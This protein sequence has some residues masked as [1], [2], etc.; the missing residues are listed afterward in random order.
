MPIIRLARSRVNAATIA[1][2]LAAATTLAHAR[3]TEEPAV[4]AAKAAIDPF[5]LQQRVAGRSDVDLASIWQSLGL[6]SRLDTIDARRSPAAAEAPQFT[7]CHIECVAEITRDNLDADP[8]PEL[9]LKICEPY[10]FC[11]FLFF[12]AR[13]GAESSWIL[14][15]HAD[16]DIARHD[17][18]TYAVRTFGDT[19][20]FVM[21]A[22]G[23]YGTGISFWYAR[24]FEVATT[25]AREVLTLPDR[26]YVDLSSH[27]MGRQFR[28]DVSS[29]TLDAAGDRF[30]VTFIVDYAGDSALIDPAVSAPIPLLT[31]VQHGAYARAQQE[32]LFTLDESGSTITAA[33]INSVFASDDVGCSDALRIN[34][35]DLIPLA[36]RANG[37]TAEWLRR[38][39]TDCP[40]SDVRT[41][42]L[43]VL[44]R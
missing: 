41:R 20:F 29:Y 25:G 23:A 42:L 31:R 44:H 36:T 9:I 2:A 15:G 16:H 3:A 12:K 10:G 5:A 28:T 38:Y 7:T 8:E 30:D 34:E 24:W 14:L 17:L 19:R 39:V 4:A 35:S 27:G 22:E 37:R 40:A 21:N 26:G 32:S 1:V 18:P 6:S 43:S 13:R 11:R 33:E